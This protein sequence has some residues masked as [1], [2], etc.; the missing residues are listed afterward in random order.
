MR[1]RRQRGPGLG[2]AGAP[3][4]RPA[5]AAEAQASPQ[6]PAGG[7]A[8]GLRRALLR[9]GDCGGRVNSTQGR[10]RPQLSPKEGG[11]GG[12]LDACEARHGGE[13]KK[14]GWPR[15]YREGAGIEL[16]GQP[17]GPLRLGGAGTTFPIGPLPAW[18]GKRKCLGCS[19]QA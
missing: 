1:R 16:P 12:R 6:L 17:L 11:P 3:A 8:G 7:F 2:T 9:G 18:E 19:A 10:R 15:V 4:L 14:P 5:G 13:A